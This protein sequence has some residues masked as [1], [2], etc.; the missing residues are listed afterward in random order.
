MYNVAINN[1]LENLA[2]VNYESKL[3][4]KNM[5]FTKKTNKY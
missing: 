3:Q 1:D 2:N 5:R 4:S